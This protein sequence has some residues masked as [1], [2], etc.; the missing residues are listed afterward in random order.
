[1]RSATSRVTSIPRGPAHAPSPSHKPRHPH[2]APLEG[3]QLWPHIQVE[4]Q[5]ARVRGALSLIEINHVLYAR[6][7][8]IDDPVMPVKRRRVAEPAVRTRARAQ[9]RR[10]A[11][12]GHE[13]RAAAR[14]ATVATAAL[15]R[16]NLGPRALVDRIVDRDDGLHVGCAR[17]VPLARHGGEELRFGWVHPVPCRRGMRVAS[18]LGV[19]RCGGGTGDGRCER[20]GGGGGG[21]ASDA[22]A[23]GDARDL[24]RRTEGGGK[25]GWR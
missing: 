4:A 9:L 17:R 8:A 12:K 24:A 7:A 10:V 3:I 2:P 22:E 1:M 20:G 23:S 15:P 19:G 14:G 11:G 25:G 6:A 21:A 13:P 5:P 18:R 16:Q